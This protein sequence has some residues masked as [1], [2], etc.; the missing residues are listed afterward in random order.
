MHKKAVTMLMMLSSLCV[1]PS[2]A[3]TAQSDTLVSRVINP[4]PVSVQLATHQLTS[5]RPLFYSVAN[6]AIFV[7]NDETSVYIFDAGTDSWST[8]SPN[9]ASR[10]DVLSAADD[11]LV[12]TDKADGAVLHILNANTVTWTTTTIPE[13][14]NWYHQTV[15]NYIF[16]SISY[17]YTLAVYNIANNTWL[18]FEEEYEMAENVIIPFKYQTYAV[19]FF[20]ARRTGYLTAWNTAGDLTRTRFDYGGEYRLFPSA[21]LAGDYLVVGGG[22]LETTYSADFSVRNPQTGEYYSGKMPTA[23]YLLTFLYADPLILFTDGNLTEAFNVETQ[24][25]QIIVV[26]IDISNTRVSTGHKLFMTYNG[27]NHAIEFDS[28]SQTWSTISFSGSRVGPVAKLGDLAAFVD[29]DNMVVFNPHTQ[30]WTR[31][32]FSSDKQF[33]NAFVVG[34]KVVIV[35]SD[36]RTVH[37]TDLAQLSSTAPTPTPTTP[38]SAPSTPLPSAPSTVPWSPWTMP[39]ASTPTTSNSPV[40][41]PS[42][43]SSSPV[44]SPSNVIA[45]VVVA[46]PKS[47]TNLDVKSSASISASIISS[48]IAATVALL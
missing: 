40:P 21:G 15:G 38:T 34:D 27:Q 28:V 12:F 9:T 20:R 47:D 35:S 17:S 48:L 10:G 37:V 39:L 11:Y 6:K 25:W 4:S 42:P 8:S 3:S 44:A 1:L 33:T 14:V 24:Q 2:C 36:E 31:A 5:S 30:Q 26:E 13:R 45:P 41:L 46:A 23:R 32:Q 22:V 16:Y 18:S 43:V 29:S 7:S 19:F